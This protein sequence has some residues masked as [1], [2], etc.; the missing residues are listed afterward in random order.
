M[1]CP[2]NFTRNIFKD[3]SNFMKKYILEEFSFEDKITEILSQ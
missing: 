2:L 1:I 3:A